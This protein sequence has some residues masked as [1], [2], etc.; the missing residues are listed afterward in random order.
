MRHQFNEG[1]Y[2]GWF[3]V[4]TAVFIAMVGVA[5]IS[6][7]GVFVI[8]MSE[9]FGWSRSAISLAGT[10]AAIAGG[11]SQPF[12]GRVFDIVGGRRLILAG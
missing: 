9:D 8:P 4:A 3:I 1:I 2:Y 5:P 12:L 10:V 6:G 7:F 11:C